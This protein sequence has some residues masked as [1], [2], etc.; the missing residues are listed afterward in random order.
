MLLET[1]DEI[2]NIFRKKRSS[3]SEQKRKLYSRDIARNFYS[4]ISVKPNSVIAGY[5]AIGNEV[6]VSL[7][8][9][10]YTGDGHIICLPC[11]DEKEQP[12][13][14]RKYAK[15]AKLLKNRLT[16]TLEPPDNFEEVTPDIVITPLVAFDSAG[17]RLG[18]GGGY[19]DRTFEYMTGISA[20]F[21]AVGV[22]FSCQQT[23]FIRREATDFRLDA[24]A[25]EKNVLIF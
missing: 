6:D 7:L 8:L 23:G 21:L 17:T 2:R 13:V 15:G 11:V 12:L 24:V 3:L 18:Q 16:G 22:A 25:T 14:F 5:I 10:M 1:K 9:E 19:Y 4:N 20:G